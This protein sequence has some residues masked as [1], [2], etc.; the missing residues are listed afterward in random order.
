M[1]DTVRCEVCKTI[2]YRRRGHAAPDGWLFGEAIDDEGPENDAT[3]VWAC[4][5]SCA[6]R[7]WRQGPGRLDLRTGV[8]T[9]AIDENE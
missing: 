1:S 6:N 9:P 8:M 3:I 2:G 7:F 5:K 4:S